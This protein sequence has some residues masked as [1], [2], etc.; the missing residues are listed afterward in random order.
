MSIEKN[1]DELMTKLSLTFSP[2]NPCMKCD[3]TEKYCG[4]GTYIQNLSVGMKCAWY[5][6]ALSDKKKLRTYNRGE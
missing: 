2:N 3:G 6:T 1:L 5:Y 4:T